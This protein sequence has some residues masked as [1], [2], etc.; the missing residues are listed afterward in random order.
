ME[1][2]VRS[3]GEVG[4]SYW[5]RTLRGSQDRLLFQE[6]RCEFP[7]VAGVLLSH[8]VS[9]FCSNQACLLPSQMTKSIESNNVICRFIRL[10]NASFPLAS[11]LSDESVY[12]I[13][14]QRL[15][16]EK[17]GLKEV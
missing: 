8:K 9:P 14:H 10:S 4:R 2:G 7:R 3:H 12:G 17:L 1:A 16:E 13:A 11:C 15:D 5:D 6:L